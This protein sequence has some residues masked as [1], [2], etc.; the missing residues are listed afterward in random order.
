MGRKGTGTTKAIGR[1]NSLRD[2]A[3][4]ARW[5]IHS[6]SSEEF[7]VVSMIKGQNSRM[8]V[9]FGS[10]LWTAWIKT[11]CTTLKQRFNRNTLAKRG[12]GVLC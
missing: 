2:D 6:I 11:K 1:E 10:R 8:R 9:A 4:V 7:Q 12:T 3:L 5:S